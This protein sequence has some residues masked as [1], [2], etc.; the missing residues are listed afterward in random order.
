MTCCAWNTLLR[1]NEASF[2]LVP[3]E[4]YREMREWFFAGSK[5]EDI[6]GS[7]LLVAESFLELDS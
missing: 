5:Y 3:F 7:R 6:L 4:P 1:Q 2:V